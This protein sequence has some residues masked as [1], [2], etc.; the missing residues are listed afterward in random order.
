MGFDDLEKASSKENRG[1]GKRK[2][3]IPEAVV[4]AVIGLHIGAKIKVKVRTQLSEE[5][6]VNFGVH[7]GSVLSPLVFAIVS[8][9]DI[10]DEILYAED[11]VL[12]AETIK[13]LYLEKC[14]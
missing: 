4:G 6:E 7:Q 11:L 1:M 5:L 9:I 10:D 12:M 3:R 14:T 2:K 8:D 13:N